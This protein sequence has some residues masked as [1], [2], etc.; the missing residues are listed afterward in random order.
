MDR[1]ATFYASP[2]Y[3]QRGNG[4]PIF[5]GSRRQRG[6]SILGAIKSFAMPFLQGV[7]QNAIN[8]AK[9]EAW[10]LAKNVAL[11]AFKGRNI[12]NSLKTHGLHHAKNLGK[13]ILMDTMSQV[14]TSASRKRSKRAFRKKNKQPSAK[15][16]R[17]ANF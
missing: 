4:I 12:A 1:T 17:K 8:R 15:R 13:N 7:K 5:S 10:G 14:K 16:R 6:G 9:T 3:V 11:D 2:S